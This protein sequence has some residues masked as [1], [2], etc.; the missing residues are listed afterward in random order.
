M[1]YLTEVKTVLAAI[2]EPSEPMREAA[3]R[4][5][6][7][8]RTTIGNLDRGYRDGGNVWLVI[9]DAALAEDPST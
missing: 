4:T 8:F 2:R 1:D 6:T 3:F 9:I 5:E 7:E